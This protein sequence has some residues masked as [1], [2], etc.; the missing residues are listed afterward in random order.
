MDLTFTL[1][2]TGITWGQFE[3]DLAEVSD[4]SLDFIIGSDV[5]FD[6]SVFEP[7]C[8]TLSHLL[9]CNPSCQ[10][11]ITVQDR[12]GEWH[13]DLLFKQYGL[14]GE[15]ERPEDF[16]KD[17][18]IDTQDLTGKHTILVLKISSSAA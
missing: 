18:G 9:K 7:L 10:A 11:I 8:V 5:F 16:L 4:G 3:T 15:I 2:L 14:K 17:T 6:P 1:F 12:S 13:L